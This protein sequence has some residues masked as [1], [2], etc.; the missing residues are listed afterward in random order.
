PE[1]GRTFTSLV[2][3]AV[4]EVARL[5]DW[6]GP[7]PFKFNGPRANR[8]SRSVGEPTLAV[9]RRTCRLRPSLSVS[10]WFVHRPRLGRQGPV[11]LNL[12][13]DGKHFEGL[14]RNQTLD[15]HPVRPWMPPTRIR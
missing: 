14:C 2:I 8:T 11:I 3:E 5:P 7:S 6:P 9:I 10:I 13:P 15:L 4:F 12:D 1:P